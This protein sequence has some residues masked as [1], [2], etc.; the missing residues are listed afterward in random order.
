MK[1]PSL[2]HQ[3]PSQ[4]GRGKVWATTCADCG[5]EVCLGPG[6]KAAMVR[7]IAAVGRFCDGCRADKAGAE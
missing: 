6:S 7:L 1:A 2:L 5:K 3:V 4:M